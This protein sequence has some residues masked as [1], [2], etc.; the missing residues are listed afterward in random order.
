MLSVHGDIPPAPRPRARA[1]ATI[2]F[3]GT[4]DR[5]SRET[6]YA[7]CTTCTW[8]NDV[9]GD[10]LWHTLSRTHRRRRDTTRPRT[11]NSANPLFHT[12]ERTSWLVLAICICRCVRRSVNQAGREK[13]KK[14]SKSFPNLRRITPRAGNYVTTRLYVPWKTRRLNALWQLYRTSGLS[15]GRHRRRLIRALANYANRRTN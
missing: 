12:L 1:R 6:W 7:H 5:E 3:V 11:V 10:F 2:N 4:R 13:L 15:D 14:T 9:S 8:K